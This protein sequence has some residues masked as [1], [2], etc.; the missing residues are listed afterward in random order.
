M[1]IINYPTLYLATT[2][3][4]VLVL[5]ELLVAWMHRLLTLCKRSCEGKGITMYADECSRVL[6]LQCIFQSEANACLIQEVWKK[7]ESIIMFTI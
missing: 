6:K 7:T 5:S 1:V 2:F 4:L 3:V